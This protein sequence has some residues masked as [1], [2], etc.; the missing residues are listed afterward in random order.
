M[1]HL[2]RCAMLFSCILLAIA[3]APDA[4]A[5]PSGAA[6]STASA[7][8]RR[9]GIRGV[10]F[11][12]AFDSPFVTRLGRP[13]ERDFYLL[14]LRVARPMAVTRTTALEWTMDV[15]PFAASTHNP[16]S[17]S[18]LPSCPGQSTRCDRLLAHTSTAYAVGLVPVGLQLELFRASAVRLQ[19]ATTGGALW[20]TSAVPDPRA[21]RF[22]FTADAG[23]TLV[24]D[25]PQQ[26]ELLLGYRYHHTS[27]AG[28]GQ[29]NPGLNAHM[30]QVGIGRGGLVR[31]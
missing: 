17:F 21:T 9:F 2:A 30:L 11:S 26:Y 24:L 3:A 1:P 25:L 22:N 28:T 16:T 27:N 23:G 31:R 18:T 29:V 8:E 12:A 15:I 6:D 20:F 5:Q 14:G 10:W 19:L 4:A 7:P 13:F